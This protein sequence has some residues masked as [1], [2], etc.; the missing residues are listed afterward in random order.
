MGIKVVI[1]GA[2]ISTPKPYP[3]LQVYISSKEVYLKA[4]ATQGMKVVNLP[5][6]SGTLSP[7]GHVSSSLSSSGWEDYNEPLTLQNE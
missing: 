1:N 7:G 4:N 2:L 5:G 3:K 6:S